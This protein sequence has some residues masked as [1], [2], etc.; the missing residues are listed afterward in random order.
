LKERAVPTQLVIYP[1]E[2]HPI[3][4]RE[5]QRDMLERILAWYNRHLVIPYVA[6]GEVPCYD[7]T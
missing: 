2:G 4:E 6:G 3:Q 7:G 5:H 1:R